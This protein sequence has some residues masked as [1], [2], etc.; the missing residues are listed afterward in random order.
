MGGLGAGIFAAARERKAKAETVPIVVPV[1]VK[2]QSLRRKLNWNPE[3]KA[4]EDF[5]TVMARL[6]RTGEAKAK[7]DAPPFRLRYNLR[8]RR[9]RKHKLGRRRLRLSGWRSPRLRQEPGSYRAIGSAN[10]TPIEKAVMEMNDKHA[11]IS[12]LGGKCVIMEWVPGGLVRGRRSFLIKASKPFESGTP[13]NMLLF[14]MAVGVGRLH[15]P[16]Q[17]G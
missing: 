12:N 3:P 7:E 2:P 5:R 8:M 15:L 1:A 11:V 4:E 9:R 13:T 14:P 16:H 10:E 6:I 17:F